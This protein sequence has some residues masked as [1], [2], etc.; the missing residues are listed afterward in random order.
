MYKISTDRVDVISAEPCQ[1]INLRANSHA[2][3]NLRMQHDVLGEALGS[4]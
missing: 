2:Q 1:R 3:T 4:D